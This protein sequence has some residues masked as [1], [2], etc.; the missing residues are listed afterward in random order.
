M[1]CACLVVSVERLVWLNF[2]FFLNIDNSSREKNVA[3]KTIYLAKLYVL[4]TKST[5]P[6]VF[7]FVFDTLKCSPIS[8]SHK[9]IVICKNPLDYSRIVSCFISLYC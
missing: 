1:V 5:A 6:F 2:F 9:N 3:C 8:E 7:M 4:H